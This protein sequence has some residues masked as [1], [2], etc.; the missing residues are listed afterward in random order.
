V[1]AGIGWPGI[2]IGAPATAGAQAPL[3]QAPVAQEPLAQPVPQL[4][5]ELVAQPPHE[6]PQEL[7]LLQ[8]LPPRRRPPKAWA[9]S[10]S[11]AIPT[12]EK[13]NRTS[14]RIRNPPKKRICGGGHPGRFYFPVNSPQWR[15]QLA[16]DVPNLPIVTIISTC[17]SSLAKPAQTAPSKAIA[18]PTW[19]GCG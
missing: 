11:A 4:P 2:G 18:D 1:P 8:Q 14:T 12:R 6:L 5:H 17:E 16:I 9:S 3:A 19:T 15:S 7:Q 10:T 13:T